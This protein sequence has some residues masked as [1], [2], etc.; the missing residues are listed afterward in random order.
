M[1]QNEIGRA[2]TWARPILPLHM[3]SDGLSRRIHG[4]QEIVTAFVKLNV[5]G[6]QNAGALRYHAW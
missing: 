3:E 5:A 4:A 1:Q 2:V 6:V